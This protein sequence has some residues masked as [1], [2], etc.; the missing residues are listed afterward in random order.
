M[1][2]SPS[3]LPSFNSNAVPLRSARTHGRTCFRNRPARNKS[4]EH[5]FPCVLSQEQATFIIRRDLADVYLGHPRD[6][7][8]EKIVPHRRAGAADIISDDGDA[9]APAS[10]AALAT[11]GSGSVRSGSHDRRGGLSDCVQVFGLITR[12]AT[13]SGSRARFLPGFLLADVAIIPTRVKGSG[14]VKALVDYNRAN[15]TSTVP[16]RRDKILCLSRAFAAPIR[17]EQANKQIQ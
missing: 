14:G 10:T 11:L 15:P 13:C 1:L 4:P 3:C 7:A 16:I 9:G 2:S 17:P 5:N 12:T 6:V 8:E